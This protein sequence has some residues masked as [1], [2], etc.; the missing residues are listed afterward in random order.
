[1][2]MSYQ[3]DFEQWKTQIEAV[4]SDDIKL[5]DRP[6]DLKVAQADTLL[7]DARE[8]QE[9]LTTAG[10]D[11]QYVEDLTTLPGALRYCQA[12]W[13]SEYQSRQEAQQNWLEQSPLAYE[14]R[15]EILHHMSFAYRDE[16]DVNKKVMRI[17]EGSSHADMIQDLIELAVLA[18]KY[19]EPLAKINY[20]TSL[21]DK[22]KTT[23]HQMAE[24]LAL[25]NGAKDESSATKL[26]RDKAFT[27]LDKRMREIRA[28]G[29]YVFWQNPERKAK[30]VDDY[31]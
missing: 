13:M 22:A 15:N 26:L 5:P 24:L 30:Y 21:N 3:E 27:L 20:D 10:L 19:P 8:D 16:P 12:E 28:V 7:V 6:V 1:M 9:L 18:E 25:N 14:L 4:A 2:N 23:S 17:R 31:N 11:W 29:Q